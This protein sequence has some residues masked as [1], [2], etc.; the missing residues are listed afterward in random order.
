[1]LIINSGIALCQL[2]PG[3]FKIRLVDLAGNQIAV[4]LQAIQAEVVPH[5]DGTCTL[6]GNNSIL[7]DLIYTLKCAT[8][9]VATDINDVFVDNC[10]NSEMEFYGYAIQDQAGADFIGGY[11][12]HRFFANNTPTD[13]PED[14]IL[15]TWMPVCTMN[16]A[17][18]IDPA[19]ISIISWDE[20]I[21]TFGLGTE[22]NISIDEGSGEVAYTPMVE[23]VL[24]LDLLSFNAQKFE[25]RSAILTWS[26]VNE[27]NTSHFTVERSINRLTWQEAGKVKAAGENSAI[28][29]YQFIDQNVYD[30]RRASVRY[31]YRLNIVDRDARA[32]RSNIE[33]VQFSTNLAVASVYVFPNPS[34]DGVNIELN[35]PEDHIAVPAQILVYNGLGQLVYTQEVSENSTLEFIDFS[36][37]NI[38]SGAYSLQVMDQTNGILATEKIVVQR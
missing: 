22:P 2:N 6:S 5:G 25:E 24:P 13:F 33:V 35:Y 27:I 15:N 37:T 19:T 28:L 8:C 9:D 3:N 7:L 21:G 34:I 32:A 11:Y 23:E 10:T 16:H 38:N 26:T 20:A 12:L 4:E 18:D 14:W 29:Q 31:Y 1:M 30:G 17:A 36:K